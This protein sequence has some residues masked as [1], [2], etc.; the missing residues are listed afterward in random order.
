M[1]NTKSK[2]LRAAE[3]LFARQGFSATSVRMITAEAQVNL[4]AI[5]YHFGSKD[6]LIAE[7]LSRRLAPLNQERL[8]RLE[9]SEAQAGS[10]PPPLEKVL[11]AFVAP[12]LLLSRD[13]KRGGVRFMRLLG[14]AFS[15]PEEKIRDILY[16]QFTE[17]AQGFTAALARILHH[18]SQE[19]LFW[20]FHFMIGAMAHT[21]N[22]IAD[23]R[24][25]AQISRVEVTSDV[26][27]VIARLVPFLAEGFSIPARRRKQK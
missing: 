18:L 22:V 25:I 3:R 20:R 21:M 17:V 2:I 15:E 27:M 26:E 12:P 16:S 9:A 19:E 14:R 24:A 7:L 8:A 11:E 23:T 4:A 5:H 10:K 6:R 13:P 1:K